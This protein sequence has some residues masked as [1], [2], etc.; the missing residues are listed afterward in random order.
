MS[1][2]VNTFPVERSVRLLPG[3]WVEFYDDKEFLNETIRGPFYVYTREYSTHGSSYELFN[4]VGE[5]FDYWSLGRKLGSHDL[6]DKIKVRVLL[7]REVVSKFIS[8]KGPKGESQDQLMEDIKQVIY[9]GWKKIEAVRQDKKE[10]S[11]K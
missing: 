1:F 4:V 11:S 2:A 9:E 5:L 7:E 8:C 3:Q 10:S 6:H